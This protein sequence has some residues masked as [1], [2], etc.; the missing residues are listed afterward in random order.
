MADLVSVD[1]GA[2]LAGWHGDAAVTIPIG[3]VSAAD[4]RC[5]QLASRRCMPG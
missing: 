5:P 3:A 1:C 4:S 2:I